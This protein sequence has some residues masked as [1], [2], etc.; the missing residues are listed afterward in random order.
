MK[1]IAWN[2]QHKDLLATGGRDG[3]ICIWDLRMPSIQSTENGVPVVNPV[4]TMAGA[5]EVGSPKGRGR[6]QKGKFT[7]RS[8]TNL[9]YTGTDPHGLISSGS[10]DGY[11]FP[12]S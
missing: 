3:S 12:R 4:Q 11:G 9:L 1:C 6:P 2:P 10:F 7:A 8:V 5:H